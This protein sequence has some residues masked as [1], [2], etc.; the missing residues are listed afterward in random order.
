VKAKKVKEA[1]KKWQERPTIDQPKKTPKKVIVEPEEV[2]ETVTKAVE[3]AGSAY[4]KTISPDPNDVTLP[5]EPKVSKPKRKKDDDEV[6]DNDKPKVSKPKRNKDDDE[7]DDNEV[8]D[9]DEPKKKHRRTLAQIMTGLPDKTNISE[10]FKDMM[11]A[12][13]M[14]VNDEDISRVEDEK[15]KVSDL[16]KKLKVAKDNL[17]K[18]ELAAAKKL[19]YQ[20]MLEEEFSNIQSSFL[21]FSSP[22][23]VKKTMSAKDL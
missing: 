16:E 18:L 17:A 11:V 10:R 5:D 1:N 22:K 7:V 23:K 9:N 19:E 4:F 8:D 3:K 20:A 2:E 14:L 6:N 13:N 12:K 21:N 15:Q